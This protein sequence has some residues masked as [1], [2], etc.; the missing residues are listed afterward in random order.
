MKGFSGVDV[1]IIDSE[2][3]MA[4]PTNTKC[5]VTATTL[6]PVKL[7][8]EIRLS[9]VGLVGSAT[10]KIASASAMRAATYA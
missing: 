10:S 3:A 9:K 8:S 1:L 2:S 6:A 4:A 5:P 7:T